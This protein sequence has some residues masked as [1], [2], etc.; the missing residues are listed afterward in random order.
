V[1]AEKNTNTVMGNKL[2]S[3]GDEILSTAVRMCI[4]TGMSFNKLWSDGGE[5]S[6][7]KLEK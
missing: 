7:D 5:Q 4:A 6:Y 2:R 3:E 1:E